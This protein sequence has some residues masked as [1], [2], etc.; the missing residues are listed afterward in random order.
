MEQDGK[1]FLQRTI[2]LSTKN[3]CWTIIA[4]SI[5]IGIFLI[6]G[7]FKPGY[8]MNFDNPLRQ[9]LLQCYKQSP[10]WLLTATWCS[11]LQ[12]G[13]A[14]FQAYPPIFN[15][16]VIF[17]WW[18]FSL[19]IAYKMALMVSW[20]LLPSIIAWILWQHKHPLAAA[21]AFALILLDIGIPDQTGL[22]FMLLMGSGANQI[23]DF[24]LFFLLISI[25]ISFFINPTKKRLV[26]ISLVTALYILAHPTTSV[27]V[28]P[29]L[30]FLYLKFRK[31]LVN[32][33]HLILSYPLLVILLA[34]YYLIPIAFNLESNDPSG[35]ST[36]SIGIWPLAIS[37]ITAH[38]HPLI[39][40]LGILGLTLAAFGPRDL[41]AFP[42]IFFSIMIIWTINPLFSTIP[43]SGILPLNRTIGINYY[44]LL[45]G[46]ALF[47]ERLTEWNYSKKQ[48]NTIGI[49]A[50]VIIFLFLTFHLTIESNSRLKNITTSDH[51]SYQP[52]LKI[53]QELKSINGR[54]LLEETYGQTPYPVN[55]ST[56]WGIGPL[57]SPSDLIH[58]TLRFFKHPYSGTQGDA[59]QG[60]QINSFTQPQLLAIMET[61][62]IEYIVALGKTYKDT[63]AFLPKQEYGN[64]TIFKNTATPVN[65]FRSEGGTIQEFSYHK[66]SA[67][68]N[69]DS[70]KG[71]SLLF[72][73]RYWNNWKATIDEEPTPITRTSQEYMELDV[74]KGKHTIQFEYKMRWWDY[75]G[76]LMSLTGIALLILIYR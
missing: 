22:E 35:L 44:I 49:I 45:I 71:T 33:Q 16:V 50:T 20:L 27:F 6:S 25:A 68:T 60:W 54:I 1:G 70:N 34:G 46:A 15:H 55:L 67:K 18:F 63:F 4:M 58:P 53:L 41:W 76:L 36:E 29:V 43:G 65:F 5:F 42:A 61:F 57:Y 11:Y 14:P 30:I 37:Q 23:I 73:V 26:G 72:K 56:M 47:L 38:A 74:P 32:H 28:L 51:P 3:I 17:F 21:M 8:I 59:L 12:A 10:I 64:I 19:Q 52:Y 40:L 7:L 69:V 13:I 48:T 39:I 66:T 24:A 75:L 62:N 9:G 2:T 31:N